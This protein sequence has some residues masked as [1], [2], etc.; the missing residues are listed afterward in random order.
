MSQPEIVVR[1]LQPADTS[2]WDEYVIGHQQGSPFHL[3]AW[4][5]AI[6]NAFGHE[7][8]YFAAWQGSNLCG[9]LPLT[10]V[11][12]ILFGN[13]LS[14]VGFAA[15]GGILADNDDIYNKMLTVA[16]QEAVRL[17]TDYVELKWREA[18][19]CDLPANDLY[20]TFI[21]KLSSDHDE[22]LM[23]IPRK[24]RAMVRKGIK[25]GL[26]V[27]VGNEYLND[28]YNIF[29]INVHRLGTPVYGKN[30]FAALLTSFGEQAEIQVIEYEGKIISGV[31]TLYFRDTVLPYYAASLVEYRKYAP[32][33]FQ[34]WMLM[35][36]AVEKGYRYFDYGRSKKGTGHFRFKKHWG[37]EPSQLH[38]RYVLHKTSNVPQMNP[39]NPRYKRK[40]E[41]WRKLPLAA[42]KVLGPHL[43]K[44]IP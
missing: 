24:Q 23:A 3:T 41:A 44:Y 12:S 9:I 7:S 39:L 27:H 26:K 5:N 33:D 19:E 36:R 16:Q 35:Q 37:F 13:I 1:S 15:Y 2:L 8:Y 34:Y 32:N 14:S 17:N 18:P 20:V 25:S 21:K 31:F 4:R 22:N 38:Y 6:S 40:I 30:W 43:V 10:H 28:F 42:T 11:K 29:A